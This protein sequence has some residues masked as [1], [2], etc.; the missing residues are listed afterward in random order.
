MGRKISKKKNDELAE[1]MSDYIG[2]SKDYILSKNLRI[3]LDEFN[4]E[5][6]KDEKLVIGMIIFPSPTILRG[7]CSM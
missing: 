4:T 6:L 2:L 5:L 7:T 3:T 1:K